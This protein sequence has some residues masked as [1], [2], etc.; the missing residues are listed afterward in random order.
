M[1]NR[2]CRLCCRNVPDKRSVALF[3][4]TSK[5]LELPRRI[6]D[7]LHVLVESDDELSAYI[8]VFCKKRL[9]KLEN[10]VSDLDD[11]RRQARRNVSPVT[12][13]NVSE[14]RVKT[15]SGDGASPHTVCSRP[16]AKRWDGRDGRRMIDLFDEIGNFVSS[17]ISLPLLIKRTSR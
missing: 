5:N 2:L 10:S 14:K 12:L 15:T 9:H 3:T 6:Q 7:L 17:V 11:F 4:R 16:A 13:V 1:P 8:C